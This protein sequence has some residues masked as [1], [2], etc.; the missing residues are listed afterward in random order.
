MAASSVPDIRA[1][2][3]L[4][5]PKYSVTIDWKLLDDGTLDDKQALATAAIIALGTNALADSSEQLPDPDSNDRQGWWGDTDADIWDGWPVGSKL[6]LLRRSAIEGPNAQR[7]STVARVKAYIVQAIQPFVDRRICSRF[8]V[9]A[10]RA[11]DQ[12]INALV[13]MYRGPLPAIEL[14]YAILWQEQ[15]IDS[16]Y[17]YAM[18][19]P[20]IT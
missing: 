15:A 3:N 7:G 6:W 18:G 20:D 8:T 9:E 12:Q 13:R 2:Q 17:S 1:V 11:S 16:E 14:R 10:E 4:E 5:F 19:Y